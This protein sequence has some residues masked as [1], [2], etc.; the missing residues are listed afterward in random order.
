MTVRGQIAAGRFYPADAQLLLAQVQAC[1][2]H[3]LGPGA[4]AAAPHERIDSWFTT[5]PLALIVPHGALGHSGPVAAHAYALL[6]RLAASQR[7]TLPRL[8]VLLGPDH[9]GRGAAVST[10]TLDYAT[11]LGVISTDQTF[12]QRLCAE[13]P[14]QGLARRLENAPAGHCEE[15]SLENQLPFLQH[16]AGRVLQ[17]PGELH[18][19]GEG[20]GQ[21]LVVLP[22]TMAAQDLATAESLARLFDAVLP[23]D[24]VL[25]L[26]TSDM[27]HCGPLY[28]DPARPAGRDADAIAA[29]CEQKRRLAIQAIEGMDAAHLVECFYAHQLSMCGLGCVATAITFAR[30]RGATS[31]RVL[32]SSDSVAVA[33]RWGGLVPHDSADNIIYPW[34][35][36]S[37]VDPRN[38]VGFAT[39][40]FC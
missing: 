38:P 8:V 36:L 12:V 32:A 37:E 33:R 2:R 31:A 22:V 6:G 17:E 11:P 13:A 24:G 26:V 28:G 10:T 1:Y 7:G 15:H 18:P 23:K 25:L 40:A 34:N 14:N 39:I 9:L 30:L 21:R 16:L 3:P 35:L 5:P 29:W 27:S 20:I 19:L 4:L